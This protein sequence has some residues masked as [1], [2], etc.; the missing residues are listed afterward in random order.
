[1][2]A[3]HEA[4]AIE[5]LEHVVATEPAL[6]ALALLVSRKT[7]GI[8]RRDLALGDEVDDVALGHDGT[9]DVLVVDEPGQQVGH[10]AGIIGS[11]GIGL[12]HLG[13]RTTGIGTDG[14]GLGGMIAQRVR[15][16]DPPDMRVALEAATQTRRIPA[17]GKGVGVLVDTL[18]RGRIQLDERGAVAKPLDG[19]GLLAHPHALVGKARRDAVE[20]GA[21]QRVEAGYLEIAGVGAQAPELLEHVGHRAVG[22]IPVRDVHGG[23][24]VAVGEHA[25]EVHSAQNRPVHDGEL[26]GNARVGEGVGGILEAIDLPGTD[27][28]KVGQ[29]L[30]AI[31]A[32]GHGGDLGHVPVGERGNRL[33]RACALQEIGHVGDLGGVPRARERGERA[34]ALQH[35]GDA[36]GVGHIHLGAVKALH[37]R[38][39]G[40]PVGGI[41]DE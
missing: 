23:E 5:V 3:D 37:R 11:A 2:I 16:E 9:V 31:E 18:A 34:R 22:R 27:L 13:A 8:H 28:V 15:V 19:R 7:C 26:V 38:V 29:A 21:H 39:A 35:V 33:E 20:A 24:L 36:G 17:V 12:G 14:Q 1:M 10:V 32:M 6:E 41:V 4:L 25:R 40:K 30:H